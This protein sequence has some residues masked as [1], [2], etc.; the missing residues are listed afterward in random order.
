MSKRIIGAGQLSRRILGAVG[1]SAV[2][3]MGAAVGFGG[4]ALAGGEGHGGWGGWGG[5]DAGWS[6]EESGHHT[7]T[8]VGCSASNSQD[9]NLVTANVAGNLLN[10]NNILSNCP[11]T[12]SAS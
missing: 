2:V 6:H 11:S 9:G 10:G 5:N 3:A 7:A 8:A 1:A 12:A 4:N